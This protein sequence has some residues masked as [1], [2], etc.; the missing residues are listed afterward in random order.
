MER[1]AR[2]LAG[3]VPERD[4]DR[5]GGAH[6][7]A[8]AARADVAAQR[9]RVPLDQGGILADQVAGD[10]MDVRLD[11]VGEEERL[12]E[13]DEPLVGV[14]EHVHEAREL[15][16]AQGVDPRDLHSENWKREAPPST[17]RTEPVMYSASGEQRNPTALA[18]CSA[19]P[20]SPSGITIEARR[21]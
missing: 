14:D 4:V 18:I 16:D 6:L 21:A 2:G 10:R 11:R 15:L 12:A 5:R 9:A 20:S 3:E 8:A 17:S 7:G 19:V 1:P 13:P